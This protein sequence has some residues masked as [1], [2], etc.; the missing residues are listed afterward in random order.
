MAKPKAT[1]SAGG[2][3]ISS[4]PFTPQPVAQPSIYQFFASGT[5][6][7]FD[8]GAVL[9]AAWSTKHHTDPADLLLDIANDEVCLLGHRQWNAEQYDELRPDIA[10]ASSF[11]Q[12]RRH[13]AAAVADEA[14]LNLKWVVPVRR[15]PNVQLAFLLQLQRRP[16]HPSLLDVMTHL[17]KLSESQ[18]TLFYCEFGIGGASNEVLAQAAIETRQLDHLIAA[19]EIPRLTG[20]VNTW[21]K[22]E[23]RVEVHEL[24]ARYPQIRLLSHEVFHSESFEAL[25]TKAVQL[26][27]TNKL[28]LQ[29][30]R[31]QLEEH[32][33]LESREREWDVRSSARYTS[34]QGSKVCF[35]FRLA[36]N[37][38]PSTWWTAT[39]TSWIL[40]YAEFGTGAFESELRALASSF[41]TAHNCSKLASWDDEET[42]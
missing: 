4:A 32:S 38:R 9:V 26:L 6:Q 21:F 34:K 19:V 14:R 16:I 28:V 36:K 15:S 30:Y 37:V 22:S 12:T 10:V 18:W 42:R 20:L 24:T 7:P 3:G 40:E 8:L 11:L 33:K 39:S 2:H 31:K 25:S 27:N 13:V 29:F 41:C 17:N 5:K 1:T 23:R 35:L